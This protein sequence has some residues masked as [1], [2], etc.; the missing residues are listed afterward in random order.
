MMIAT[1]PGAVA[2]DDADRKATAL[3]FYDEMNLFL[4]TLS[5][6]WLDER[7]H[8]D[9]NEYQAAIQA[10]ADGYGIKVTKMTKRPFG[11][12]YELGGRTYQVKVTAAGAYS[13]RRIK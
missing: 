13:Y 6:R 1:N 8:E 3:R 11:F 2:M 5:M 12:F 7:E 4:G 9:I 10:Q